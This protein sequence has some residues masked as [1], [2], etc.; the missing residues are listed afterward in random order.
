MRDY[1]YAFQVNDKGIRDT[2]VSA[3]RRDGY[4]VSVAIKLERNPFV[5]APT[6]HECYFVVVH[7]D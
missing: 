4:R 6:L 3:L 2:I 5:R 7:A 1:A